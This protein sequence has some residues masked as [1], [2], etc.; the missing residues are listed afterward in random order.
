MLKLNWDL[1]ICW[2]GLAAQPPKRFSR[3]EAVERQRD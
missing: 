1:S 2:I 3:G